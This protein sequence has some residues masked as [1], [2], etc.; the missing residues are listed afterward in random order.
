[1]I[2]EG[3]KIKQNLRK[4][5]K[6][7]QKDI[8]ILLEKIKKSQKQWK[9][10]VLAIF[11]LAKGWF[12]DDFWREEI[13]QNPGK[14]SKNHQNIIDLL[15]QI[16]KTYQQQW[17]TTVLARFLCFFQQKD[18]FL[19][20]FW[21]FFDDFLMVFEGEKIKQNPRKASKNH[22]KIII[23]LEKIKKTC[24]KQWKSKVLAS[25]LCFF[26]AKGWFYDSFLMIFWWFLKALL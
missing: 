13:K 8:I 12:F 15:E 3:E 5:S 23:L 25:F 11:F 16:K 6:N 24:Q 7:H 20:I 14:S 19:M 22:Q 18:D 1:M 26:L 2:L 21:W 4:P 9:S 17:K 10:K